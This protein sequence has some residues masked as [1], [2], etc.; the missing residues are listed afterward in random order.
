MNDDEDLPESSSYRQQMQFAIEES[1]ALSKNRS[2]QET[3]VQDTSVSN[4]TVDAHVYDELFDVRFIV[5]FKN[6]S[7]LGLLLGVA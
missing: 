4:S 6:N 7:C 5:F 3:G 2:S 1:I